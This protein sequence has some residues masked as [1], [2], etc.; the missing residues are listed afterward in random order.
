MFNKKNLKT[1][2]SKNLKIRLNDFSKWE[3]RGD[4]V[5]EISSTQECFNFIVTRG[6]LEAGYGFKQLSLPNSQTDLTDYDV[7]V[8]ATELLG[9]WMAPM[10]ELQ[11]AIDKYYIFYL[12]QNKQ[13]Y[14]FN[15]FADPKLMIP[16]SSMIF[17]EIPYAAQF[18]INGYDTMLFSSPS[19]QTIGLSF[20]GVITYDNIPKFLSGCW[21][22]TYFFLVTTGDRNQLVYSTETIANWNDNNKFD[23]DL[24]D[25]RGGL[26]F[27]IS[28]HDDLYIFRDYG[29]IKLSLYGD[30]EKKFDIQN[31]Y[32]SS[33]YIY[34]SSIA[35]NGDFII[36]ATQDG[37]Y[38]FD[39]A[40]VNKIELPFEGKFIQTRNSS[41]AVA[42]FQNKYFLACKIDFDDA[43]Q[44]GVESGNFENNVV[45]VYDIQTK[46]KS[47]IRGIDVR[48]FCVVN[49][50]QFQK[51][52]A[53]FRGDKKAV[54]GELTND[55]AFFGTQLKKIWHS[56]WTDFG[57]ADS[58]K[59]IK[60]VTFKPHTDCKIIIETEDGENITITSK[61]VETS[62]RILV[63][64][65][66][67]SFKISFISQ[68]NKTISCPEFDVMVVE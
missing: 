25:I 47:I 19:D 46:E 28:F 3:N 17:D 37:I 5:R 32:Y 33:S 64:L 54:I 45:I 18:R 13:V 20:A 12:N 24:P 30:A 56:P 57:Y 60:S 9:I 31:I 16:Q 29:I 22:G 42:S 53:I 36:F 63:G 35:K 6:E 52:C 50:P 7:N 4:S 15:I 66:S 10:Y 26:K 38:T 11:S 39:G 48:Q 67:K 41:I 68:S 59:K 61:D 34:P 23:V 44:V 51:L 1:K 62:Q 55:G 21:H 49:T 8:T 27:V 65:V 43:E 14:Y 40:N 2:Q 58:L